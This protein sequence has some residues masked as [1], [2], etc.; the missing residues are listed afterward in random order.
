MEAVNNIV[1]SQGKRLRLSV[2]KTWDMDKVVYNLEINE[3]EA[4]EYGLR[5]SDVTAQIQMMLRGVPKI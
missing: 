1:H 2:S 3:Q 5:R 4:M